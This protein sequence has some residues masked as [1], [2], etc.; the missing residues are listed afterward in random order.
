[1]YLT[2]SLLS[3]Q[4]SRRIEKLKHPFANISIKDLKKIHL[5]KIK[6]FTAEHFIGE[7]TKK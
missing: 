4:C 1:M 3:Y 7:I 6:R 2:R 5:R